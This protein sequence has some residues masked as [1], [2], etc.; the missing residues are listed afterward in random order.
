L[1]Y[2]HE[3]AGEGQV[4]YQDY[5]LSVLSDVVH[6]I[7]FFARLIVVAARAGK[8]KVRFDCQWVG[9]WMSVDLFVRGCS[10]MIRNQALLR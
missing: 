3:R 10:Q 5:V 2:F 4:H 7:L 8:Q 1:P 6:Y 9:G